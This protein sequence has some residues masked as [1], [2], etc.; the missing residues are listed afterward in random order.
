MK[1]EI[2]AVKQWSVR[3]P[4]IWEAKKKEKKDTDAS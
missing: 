3:R 4:S 1:A 2:C